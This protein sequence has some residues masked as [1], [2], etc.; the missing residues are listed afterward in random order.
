MPK[1]MFQANYTPEGVKGL[2]KDGGSKRREAVEA[3]FKSLGGKLEAFYYTFGDPDV[4]VIADMPDNMSAAAASVAI[5][6][7]GAVTLKTTVLLS[8]EE[9][10]AATKKTVNYRRP[11]Q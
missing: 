6:S 10:D 1:Y 8:L 3:A 9:M 4:V 11:G 7:S 5:N 2:A